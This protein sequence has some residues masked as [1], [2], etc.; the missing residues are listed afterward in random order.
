MT[1][2][3]IHAELLLDS[4]LAE[5]AETEWRDMLDR[6]GVEAEGGRALPH[7]AAGPLD[8]LVLL[9]LPLHAFLSTLGA[10]AVTDLYET[11]KRLARQ[12]KQIRGQRRP[13]VLEDTETGLR[14]L[15]DA[16]LP[17]EALEQLLEIRLSDFEKGPLHYDRSH[18]AWRSIAD[19]ADR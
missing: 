19:E 8:W 10:A 17:R 12:S 15:V 3:S 11:V 18:R 14:I 7:R 13:L 6:I 9:V 4:E 2:P 1:H 5:S 16:D